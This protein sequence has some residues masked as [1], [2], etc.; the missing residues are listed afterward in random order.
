MTFGIVQ[1]RECLH[2]F[3][4][5]AIHS[6]AQQDNWQAQ[7]SES[8]GSSTSTS[9]RRLHIQHRRFVTSHSPFSH[10]ITPDTPLEYD[11][12]QLAIVYD[13]HT[14]AGMR[15]RRTC[16]QPIDEKTR[17][18]QNEVRNL[19]TP[20]LRWPVYLQILMNGGNLTRVGRAWLGSGAVGIY[21]GV[22]LLWYR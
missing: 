9:S 22:L 11:D 10:I 3:P 8:E 16:H 2:V 5:S 17:G 7:S 21:Y 1:G 13:T 18:D 20:T 12:W 19:A 6:M 14:R 4:V 15:W